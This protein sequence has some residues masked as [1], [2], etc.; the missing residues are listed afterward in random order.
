MTIFSGFYYF[1]ISQCFVID[2]LFLHSLNDW[3]E[4]DKN[5]YFTNLRLQPN[6]NLFINRQI[7]KIHR[8]MCNGL[9]NKSKIFDFT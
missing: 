1:I 3:F 8:C 4:N 2:S 9:Y 7:D 6:K 5:S